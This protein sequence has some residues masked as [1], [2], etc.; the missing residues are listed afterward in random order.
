MRMA[1]YSFRT[2]QYEA[3][4][5]MVPGE[6][7]QVPIFNDKSMV[8]PVMRKSSKEIKNRYP[9]YKITLDMESNRRREAQ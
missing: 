8:I 4:K 9:R 6:R 3:R 1:L 5:P 2:A 7:S